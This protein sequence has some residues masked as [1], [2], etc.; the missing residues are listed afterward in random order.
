MRGLRG[1]MSMQPAVSA[2]AGVGKG[3]NPRTG[4]GLQGV[5]VARTRRVTLREAADILGVSKDAVR[6]RISRGTLPSDIG[7]DG[8]RYVYLDEGE[9]ADHHDNVNEVD[10]RD[11]LVSEMR[12]RIEFLQRELE[13]KDHLLAAALERIP[14]QLEAPREPHNQPESGPGEG[15]RVG[16]P[17][18][19]ESGVS[20][21]WWRRWF[22]R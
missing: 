2:C 6:K 10:P 17:Q 16:T 22:S 14:P 8:R 4:N 11:A 12:D 3:K 15:E 21:P 9:G 1:S 18:Q 7:E 13:R 19:A 5:T 20:R